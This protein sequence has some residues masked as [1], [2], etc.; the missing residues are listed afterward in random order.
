MVLTFIKC[1]ALVTLLYISASTQTDVNDALKSFPDLQRAKRNQDYIWEWQYWPQVQQTGVGPPTDNN[2]YNGYNQNNYQYYN[3]YSASASHN[4]QNYDSLNQQSNTH[5][6]VKRESPF[7]FIPPPVQN[8]LKNIPGYSWVQSNNPGTTYTHTF[9]GDP[10]RDVYNAIFGPEQ[11]NR[12]L[13]TVQPTYVQEQPSNQNN[14]QSSNQYNPNSEYDNNINRQQYNEVS[15]QP[16]VTEI[17]DINSRNVY[18]T[19]YN[20][21]PQQQFGTPDNQYA[22]NQLSN[23]QQTQATVNQQYGN[24]NAP[25]PVDQRPNAA[26]QVQYGYQYQAPASTQLSTQQQTIQTSNIQT[27]MK[28]YQTSV[29]VQQTYVQTPTAPSGT[30]PNQDTSFQINQASH[31][32]M[33]TQN[34]PNYQTQVQQNTQYQTQLKPTYT[35]PPMVSSSTLQSNTLQVVKTER[36]T[37]TSWQNPATSLVMDSQQQGASISQTIQNGAVQNQEINRND[38]KYYNTSPKFVEEN[39]VTETIPGSL[40]TTTDNKITGG[41]DFRNEALQIYGTVI[42]NTPYAPL[43]NKTMQKGQTAIKATNNKATVTPTSTIPVQIKTENRFGFAP[44]SKPSATHK[45][46]ASSTTIKP[47]TKCDT[48]MYQPIPDFRKAGRRISQI[49]CYEYIWEQQNRVNKWNAKLECY[50]AQNETLYIAGKPGM[51]AQ[52]PHMAALGWI[53]TNNA[54]IFKCAGSLISPKFVLTAAHCSR[55]PSSDTS[56]IHAIP[57][58]VRLG[59]R[60]I[61]EK[62]RHGSI[63][64]DVEIKSITVHPNYSP[65]KQYNDIAVIQLKK[66]VEFTKHVQPACLWSNPDTSKL[67]NNFVATGWGIVDT[68][69]QKSPSPTLQKVAV[70]VIDTGTC[71]RNTQPNFYE[72]WSGVMD[73]QICGMELNGTLNACRGDSGGPLQV[74]IPLTSEIEGSM[75]YVIAVTS[76]RV[77]CEKSNLP[78]IFSMVV[79]FIDWIENVVWTSNM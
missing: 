23:S 51:P 71:N 32:N 59:D 52:Y 43:N 55:T 68:G 39:Q 15:I 8:I 41:L 11:T 21:Q 47:I 33:P 19:E 62:V 17:I 37:L 70:S 50:R 57:Q 75:H 53:G 25:S 36:P 42:E 74:K 38:P 65:P 66:E 77:G 40:P 73:H 1:S 13:Q 45:E 35:Q 34:V 7:N 48:N 69:I 60:D 5:P 26:S 79:S 9:E 56:V 72:N 29:P 6:G 44:D 28:T 30:Q 24:F 3:Q 67:G 64:V 18:N 63:V 78:V 2:G 46:Q 4:N 76:F 10:L 27:P 12:I 61:A 22:T 54:W 20:N 49:K 14:Y 31:I 16:S 58:I